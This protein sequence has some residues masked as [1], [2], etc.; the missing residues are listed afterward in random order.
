MGQQ[1]DTLLWVRLHKSPDDASG[2]GGDWH[3]KLHRPFRSSWM[4]FAMDH[5][6]AAGCL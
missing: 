6:V 4:T 3:F 2:G 5:D 1:G